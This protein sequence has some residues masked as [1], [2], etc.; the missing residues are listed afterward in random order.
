[1]RMQLEMMCM[2]LQ[3]SN[4]GQQASSFN[5]PQPSAPSQFEGFSSSSNH[6]FPNL[7]DGQSFD[8]PY[9]L[10]EKDFSFDL[11]D[12]AGFDEDSTC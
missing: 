10:L 1:M 3:M 6:S 5:L 4:G 11:G 2:Q 9:S 7:P 8:S 12:H